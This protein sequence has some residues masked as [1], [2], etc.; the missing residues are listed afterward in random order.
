[1]SVLLII[2]GDVIQKAIAQ[3]SG[4]YLVPVAFSF[5]WVAYSF[6]TL[7]SI[8]GDGRLM[9]PPDYDAK[10]INAENGYVRDNKSWI[11]GRLMRDFEHPLLDNVGL[12]VTVFEA[13]SDKKAGVPS[14]DWCWA[15][16][17]VVIVVQ[18]GISA[19][20]Y[21]LY[22]DW[23]ILLVTVAGV[24]LALA[25]GLLP[26]WKFEKWACRRN[27]KKVLCLTGGNG[28]RYVMVIIGKGHGLD[29]EDLAV[30]ESPRMRRRGEK[31]SQWKN[32]ISDNGSEKTVK[33]TTLMI[34]DLPA[35]FWITRAACMTLACLWLVFL[36]TVTS[37]KQNT[38]YLLAVGG[39]GMIQNIV[40]AGAR[41]NGSTCGIHLNK[42]EKFEQ[43]KAM[44][45]L[46][47]LETAYERVG[48]SLVPEF[49]SDPDSLRPAEKKWWYGDG[50]KEEYE[51]SRREKRPDSLSDRPLSIDSDAYKAREDHKRSFSKK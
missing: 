19:I 26:Q 2:G 20:P 18:L 6:S 24:L 38:W 42:V 10:V 31:R 15:S 9:P 1:L 22:Q 43:M 8:V 4:R 50:E 48:R 28:T 30:A 25:T 12:S 46:M 27:T 23:G 5:G 16:G 35:A 13:A 47:D 37:L 51:K 36:I 45:T 39:L 33:K 3:L 14:I 29:L 40:T 17:L 44:D 7:M 11:L 34:S 41:R 49:F 32:I 21:A